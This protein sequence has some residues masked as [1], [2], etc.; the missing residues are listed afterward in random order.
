M[1]SPNLSIV[2]S[3]GCS[4]SAF[5]LGSFLWL[6]IPVLVL[7]EFFRSSLTTRPLLESAWTLINVTLIIQKRFQWWNS[8]KIRKPPYELA[9]L[10]F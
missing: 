4:K 6:L 1:A 5:V 2:P 9:G 10:F 3:V 7:E 8:Q